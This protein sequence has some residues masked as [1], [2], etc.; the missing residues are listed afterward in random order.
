MQALAKLL[1][2]FCL[3]FSFN[4]PA[5]IPVQSSASFSAVFF[6][7]VCV[8]ACVCVCV[9]V[10][11][12]VLFFSQALDYPNKFW[13]MNPCDNGVFWTQQISCK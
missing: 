2:S 4:G 12:C 7:C 5:Q 10:L 6:I 3:F 9:G 1:G 8:C 13:G 11:L